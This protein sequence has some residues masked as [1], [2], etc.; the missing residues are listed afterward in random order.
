MMPDYDALIIGGGP[1]GATT[2]ALLARAGWRVAV[3]ERARFP[4]RKV[5]GEFVS[6]PSW[7]LLRALG[8]DARSAGPAIR[9]IALY[10]DDASLDVPMPAARDG[11]GHALG[12]DVLDTALLACAA[13]HGADVLQPCSVRSVERIGGV[14]ACTTGAGE[15]IRARIVVAA[16][17]SWETGPLPTQPPRR[18]RRPKDLLAFKAHFR[19][20]RLARH[21]MPLLLFAGGYG[22]MVHTDQD[23]L[24]LSLCIRRDRLAECRRAVAAGTSAGDAVLARLLAS[25]G[26]VREAL[27]GAT[28]DGP[29][30]AAGPIRPGIRGH[31]TPGIFRVGNAMGEAHPLVAEG[32]NMAIQSAWL[33]TTLLTRHGV[34]LRGAAADDA[35]H[36][37]ARAYVAAYRRSFALRIRAAACFAMLAVHEPTRVAMSA[38]VRHAPALLA[39]GARWSGKTRPLTP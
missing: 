4:R 22:G 18:Q 33:L 23:R 3:A 2:G 15:R 19:D 11:W 9:R 38:A 14:H 32:I 7:T 25:C 16:H 37:A 24:S 1:A 26:G 10:A 31:A 39:L 20:A 30:L 29:W 35:L 8:I 27:R 17:G 21:T 12:R 5:C 6:A 34:V 36:A 13:S 28:R